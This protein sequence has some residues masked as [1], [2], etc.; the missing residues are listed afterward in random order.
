MA[1]TTL[2]L[3]SSLDS[4]PPDPHERRTALPRP[5]MLADRRAAPAR[6]RAGSGPEE[7]WRA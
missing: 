3:W 4:S 5:E 7:E 2:P 1:G 6:L